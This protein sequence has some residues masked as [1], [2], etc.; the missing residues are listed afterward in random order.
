MPKRSDWLTDYARPLAE[1]LAARC[2]SLK[3]VMSA[4]IVALYNMTPT[5]REQYM[6]KAD[7]V[8]VELGRTSEEFRHRVIE[9]VEDLEAYR[10]KKKPHRRAKPLKSG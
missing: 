7:G 8:E 3:K 6:A 4:G 1:E 5:E 9:I 2:G 10:K